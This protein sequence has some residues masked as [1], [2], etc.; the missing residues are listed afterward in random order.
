M[1]RPQLTRA[2]LLEFAAIGAAVKLQQLAAEIKNVKAQFPSLPDLG[3]NGAAPVKRTKKHWTQTPEGRRHM[4]RLQKRRHTQ[5]KETAANIL[6]HLAARKTAKKTKEQVPA[7]RKKET[8]WQTPEGRERARKI[9][10]ARWK[11]GKGIGN[12]TGKGGHKKPAEVTK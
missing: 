6:S 7:S 11:A 5:T 3:N 1:K 10:K 9:A 8:Y 12:F 2:Q 4:S